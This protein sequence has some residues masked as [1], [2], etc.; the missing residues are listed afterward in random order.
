VRRRGPLDITRSDAD[1]PSTAP[2]VPRLHSAAHDPL[3]PTRRSSPDAG[4]A[5]GVRWQHHRL[6]WAAGTLALLLTPASLLVAP[7]ASGSVGLSLTRGG[8]FAG[9][10]QL[11]AAGVPAGVSIT[12]GSSTVVDG[13]VS[14]SVSISVAAGV[15]ASTTPINITFTASGGTITSPPI[16]LALRTA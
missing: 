3:H 9:V 6:R 4:P 14:T 13:A 11:T 2:H 10:V 12:F 8:G 16:T 1:S 7:G 15:P 5:G